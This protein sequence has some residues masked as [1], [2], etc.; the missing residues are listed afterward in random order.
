MCDASDFAIG[1]VLGQQ[2]DARRSVA[3]KSFGNSCLI[4]K[5]F[6]Y[7]T[8]SALKYIRNKQDAKPRLLRWVL[9]LQEFDVPFLTRKEVISSRPI[10]C[11][12]S[13]IL[14]KMIGGIKDI[15]EHFPLETLGVISNGS[16]PWFADIANYHAGN[17]IIK[18][19]STQQKRK[20]FK[21]VK[22]YFWD[23][24]YLFRICADQIIRRCISGHEALEILKACHEVYL[25]RDVGVKPSPPGLD[26]LDDGFVE[27]RIRYSIQP[28]RCNTLSASFMEKINPTTSEA[29][30]VRLGRESIDLMLLAY[31]FV[32]TYLFFPASVEGSRHLDAP[33]SLDFLPPHHSPIIG[34]DC[35]VVR[36]KTSWL[37]S[38][39]AS[40]KGDV[41][42][43]AELLN[44]DY[45]S[46]PEYESFHVDF[47]NVPSSTHPPEK[48]PEG[49]DHFDIEPDTR[50]L[51]TKVV[52]DISNN[53][54]R[55]LYVHMPNVL[56]TLPTLYPVFDTLL[57]FSFE[58]QD[59]VF[60]PGI[61]IS[62]EEKSPH[63]LSH[64][65]F[66]V[67]QLIKDSESPM[68]IY[69]GDI[70]IL[71]VPYLHFYPP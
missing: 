67:F 43:L 32:L 28:I 40:R 6:V 34:T 24:P 33:W 8:Q 9:L 7:T 57:P 37:A 30:R 38:L 31:C 12:D 53:S 46:L 55:E 68:M 1:A 36:C 62:K 50:I 58:N 23:D 42:F 48:P 21:D 61:L 69:G 44:N 26:K 2:G 4:L 59:K 60:N 15:N 10:I 13:R 3:F 71:D 25:E 52:D 35:Q 63:L 5:A 49:D 19:M 27:F 70:P 22:H 56:L 17:F 20:F 66:K 51:T 16:T 65:G 54:T 47:Y 41:L 29:S 14:T 64:R 11:K 18:G 39:I 45:I